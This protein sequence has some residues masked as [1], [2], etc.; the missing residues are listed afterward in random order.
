MGTIG[1]ALIMWDEMLRLAA[2]TVNPRSE[3][4]VEL[5]AVEP[6]SQ[7]FKVA[8]QAIEGFAENVMDG[9]KDYPLTAKAALALGAMAAGSLIQNAL[10]PDTV[11]S[12]KQMSTLKEM[13]DSLK[14][15]VSLQKSQQQFYSIL[16]SD[17]AIDG[18]GLLAVGSRSELYYVPRDEFPDRSGL[19][20]HGPNEVY[21][22]RQ[23]I[24]RWEVTLIRAAFVPQPRRWTFA[25]DGLEFSATMEDPQVLEAIRNQRLPI[26]IAEGVRLLVEVQ[27]R[28]TFDG[29]S[30]VPDAASR[31]VTKVLKPSLPPPSVPLFPQPGTP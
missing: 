18:V 27:F 5:V 19:W 3:P 1:D 22:P 6:G 26:R 15:S 8:L 11:I 9:A 14:E 30:W 31:K 13:N 4:R 24:A 23:K 7:I 28:E 16:Q 10:A 25:R 20:D 17:P 21:K 12:A 29:R 2:T